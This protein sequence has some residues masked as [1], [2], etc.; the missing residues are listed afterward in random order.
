MVGS[1]LLC[2]GVIYL[3]FFVERTDFPLLAAAFSLAFA[4]Y[5]LLVAGR[6]GGTLKWLIGLGIALRI[7]LVFAFPRLSDDVY[8]FIWDGNLLR[9]GVNPFLE[10]P[11]YYLGAGRAPA[12]VTP[13]L[14]E[15]LNSPTYYT[16]Y[17][18]VAQGVFTAAAYLSPTD[19]YWASVW[20]KLF[21]FGCELGTLWLL[22]R[23]L[24]V[25]GDKGD[26]AQ[27]Q[28]HQPQW[29]A[30]YYWLNPLIIVEITGNLHFEGVMIF[31]LLL[32][33]HFLIGSRWAR[34]GVAMALSVA[35]KLLPLLLL[36]Y[37]L[38]RFFTRGRSPF[39]IFSVVF[40]VVLL[41]SFLPLIA[42]GGFLFGFGSSL[43]LYFRTFEFNASLYYLA[44]AYGY[45]ELGWNQI[46]RF[47]PLLAATGAMS[48]LLLSLLDRRKDW[49]SLPAG[50]LF[51]FVLYLLCATTVHPWYLAVPIVLSCFTHWR[52]PLVWSFL[53]TLTYLSYATEPYAE[54]LWVVGVEYLTVLFYF[55]WEYLTP[56]SPGEGKPSR[57]K[58]V[59][60]N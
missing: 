37:L 36:P 4:G 45:Y 31:F 15:L 14:Y 34:A 60:I 21:L 33:L 53:I 57:P 32:A 19:W 43:D 39:W 30:L 41:L 50:W 38:R 3:G 58:S 23:L 40:G 49:A 27:V 6:P 28:N 18:P 42:T 56:R 48:I 47:G 10:L 1:A 54:N 12:G 24:P 44:R 13:E 2:A 59:K 9:A 11:D 52:F 22:L 25:L 35:S 7:F 8:R 46:A 17:P 29:P 16:I 55:G 5:A 51:A 26:A 20:M